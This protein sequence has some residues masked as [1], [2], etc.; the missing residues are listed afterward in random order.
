MQ[1][2]L[3]SSLLLPRALALVLL[4]VGLSLVPDDVQRILRG[5]AVIHSVVDQPEAAPSPRPE[6]RDPLADWADH[7]ANPAVHAA[8]QAAWAC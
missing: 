8:S 6:R 5:G 2:S 7:G 1:S 3:L 4:G